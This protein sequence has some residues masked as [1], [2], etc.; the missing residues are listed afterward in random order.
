MDLQQTLSIY[1]SKALVL[2]LVIGFCVY[3]AL[4]PHTI[5]YYVA[6]FLILP[7]P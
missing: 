3:G 6:K 5:W 4:H 2:V 1:G 7:V